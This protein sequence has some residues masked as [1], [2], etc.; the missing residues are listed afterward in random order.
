MAGRIASL[1]PVPDLIRFFTRQA[2][3][4]IA[5]APEFLKNGQIE[6]REIRS[7]PLMYYVI[8]DLDRAIEYAEY[9][10]AD[11]NFSALS[12]ETKQKLAFNR[13]TFMIEREYHLPTRHASIRGKLKAE[14][15]NLLATSELHLKPTREASILDTR[16]LLKITFAETQDEVR[17]GIEDCVKARTL[18]PP[19][20]QALTDVYAD[21]NLRLGWRRYFELEGQ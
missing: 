7:V 4:W 17:A 16:G 20:E 6:E 18:S 9:L 14:I 1:R 11:S 19:E 15:E 3:E 21:L 8:G 2:H 12:E 5:R 10:A 13:A